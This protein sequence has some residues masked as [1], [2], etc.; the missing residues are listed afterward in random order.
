MRNS[1]WQNQLRVDVEPAAG[2]PGILF[3]NKVIQR[4][5]LENPLPTK[6][7]I[8]ESAHRRKRVRRIPCMSA[9]CGRQSSEPIRPSVADHRRHPKKW[10]TKCNCRARITRRT[11][12]VVQRQRLAI[13]H[14]FT[15]D[16]DPCYKRNQQIHRHT[17]PADQN[18]VIIANQH[19][20]KRVEKSGRLHWR[21]LK[22]ERASGCW[23]PFSLFF[24][25][26]LFFRVNRT[27]VAHG[28]DTLALCA[29]FPTAAFVADVPANSRHNDVW[30]IQL[31]FRFCRN[32][33]FL[34]L[35][36]EMSKKHGDP[37]ISS[38]IY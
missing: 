7:T 20:L 14:D 1:K 32:T 24:H 18:S 3:P 30:I 11:L 31:D 2:V 16:T 26:Y 29:S 17:L 12:S 23:F 22:R 4:Y 21:L 6:K 10:E 34:N 28:N 19:S 8:K 33:I 9:H 36:W 27:D 37:L 13:N 38:Q 25:F 35:A 15:D 5:S